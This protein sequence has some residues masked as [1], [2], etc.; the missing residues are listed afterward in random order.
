MVV[1]WCRD[2]GCRRR[3]SGRM[4]IRFTVVVVKRWFVVTI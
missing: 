1:V 2:G 4:V 3:G